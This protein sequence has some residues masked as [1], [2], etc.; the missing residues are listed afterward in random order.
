MI[1][2]VGK[3]SWLPIVTGAF[4]LLSQLGT[5]LDASG[6]DY[7]VSQFASNTPS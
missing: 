7:T 6:A 5:N 2:K 3:R 4:V 1:R